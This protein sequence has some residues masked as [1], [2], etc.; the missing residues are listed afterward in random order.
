MY[1]H[2]TNMSI[3]GGRRLFDAIF[4]SFK[5][6]II[7]YCCGVLFNGCKRA[8]PVKQPSLPDRF[9]RPVP[10]HLDRQFDE[11]FTTIDLRPLILVNYPR[12]HHSYKLSV[13]SVTLLTLSSAT[14]DDLVLLDVFYCSKR[15][16]F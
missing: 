15:T 11:M 14:L 5:L 4:L 10:C 16:I 13:L 12:L 6:F 1:V 9:D 3:V 7:C 8:S 2:V